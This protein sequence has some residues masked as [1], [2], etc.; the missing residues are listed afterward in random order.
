M[1]KLLLCFQGMKQRST[2]AFVLCHWPLVALIGGGIGWGL[3]SFK[4]RIRADQH[5][6]DME[7]FR[8][9]VRLH[10]DQV[11]NDLTSTKRHPLPTLKW[12]N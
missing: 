2:L 11:R 3:L 4:Q 6:K 9:W 7:M 12:S 8:D 5:E 10:I 1:P